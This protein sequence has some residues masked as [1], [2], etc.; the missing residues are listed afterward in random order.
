MPEESF[1]LENILRTHKPSFAN[2]TD[3]KP[4]NS[5]IYIP[6]LLAY[7]ASKSS[8]GFMVIQQRDPGNSQSS[9]IV[10]YVHHIPANKSP[11]EK[12]TSFPSVEEYIKAHPPLFDVESKGYI[13]STLF[14]NDETLDVLYFNS[15]NVP[16]L[17]LDVFA[18]A[19]LLT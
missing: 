2:V 14:N 5:V 12:L 16:H 6:E 1:E 10:R 19:S 3:I 13:A 4:A 8:Q 7:Q 18:L 15:V 17:A 9:G 11:G